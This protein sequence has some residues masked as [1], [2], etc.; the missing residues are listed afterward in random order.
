MITS[1]NYEY[2]FN[3]IAILQ[4]LEFAIKDYYYDKN[5]EQLYYWIIA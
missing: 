5:L 3:L 1:I 2:F 4:F